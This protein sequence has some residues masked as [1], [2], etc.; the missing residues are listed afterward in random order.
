MVVAAFIFDSVVTK[1][2]SG[3][4]RCAAASCRGPRSRFFEHWTQ[5]HSRCTGQSELSIDGVVP[6]NTNGKC[7]Q[8]HEAKFALR[9]RTKKLA[10]PRCR[11]RQRCPESLAPLDRPFA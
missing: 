8:P 11:R 6:N 1:F 2:F 5:P 10:L 7:Y 3:I 9:Q 4:G